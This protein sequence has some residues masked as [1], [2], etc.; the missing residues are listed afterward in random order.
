ML[1]LVSLIWKYLFKE[2]CST[3]LLEMTLP[4]M[5]LQF[6][7]LICLSLGEVRGYL[8]QR[9]QN[10]TVLYSFWVQDKSLVEY[11][12]NHICNWT[13]AGLLT[14]KAEFF[15][16]QSFPIVI[17]QCISKRGSYTMGWFSHHVR[18]SVANKCF[19]MT[20]YHRIS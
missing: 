11:F 3:W 16:P 14:I 4:F 20:F 8:S 9:N 5:T 2:L 12:Q 19:A 13:Y 7:I 17:F 15:F 1:V 10:T 6:P 18:E